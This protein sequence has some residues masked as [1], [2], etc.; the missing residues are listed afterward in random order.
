MSALGPNMP[1]PGLLAMLM[2][3]G[4]PPQGGPP[5]E[6]QPDTVGPLLQQALVNLVRNAAQAVLG[7]ALVGIADE[8][9]PSGREIGAAAERI[10]ERAVEIGIER[11]EGEVAAARI[12]QPVVGEGH[13]RAATVG[14]HVA[15]Q[16]GDLIDVPVGDRRHGA[17]LQ[18]GRNDLDVSGLQHAHH[19][20]G[21]CGHREI[22][23]ALHGTAGDGVAHGTADEAHADS[24]ST[25]VTVYSAMVRRCV[26]C[27]LQFE[28]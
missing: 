27:H 2:Q 14:L 7:D 26:M 25:T 6:P 10:V 20:L 17:V 12:L 23:L 4:G 8:A 15:P 9:H 19:R 13:D 21:R 22:D 16:G 1:P 18:A 24:T 5:P 11:V 28:C 3:H